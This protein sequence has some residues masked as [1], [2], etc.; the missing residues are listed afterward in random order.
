MRQVVRRDTMWGVRDVHRIVGEDEARAL[1]EAKAVAKH[2]LAAFTRTD[3]SLAV[4]GT[5]IAILLGAVAVQVP[6]E[7]KENFYQDFLLAARESEAEYER[8]YAGYGKAH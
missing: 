8:L 2:L 6:F 4:M 5:A 1:A 3:C 7:S